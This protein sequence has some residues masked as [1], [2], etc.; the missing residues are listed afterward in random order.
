MTRKKYH[1]TPAEEGWRVTAERA[2]RA[3]ALAPSK[4]EAIERARE[5]ARRQKPS[6]VIVHRRDGTIER[7]FT[8]E[9]DPYPPPG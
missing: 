8:Y 5:L 3:S 6:Q 2:E 9:K 4:Q 7:E 1:V